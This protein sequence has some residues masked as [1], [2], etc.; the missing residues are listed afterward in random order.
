MGKWRGGGLWRGAA[1]RPA[2]RALL[3]RAARG[4]SPR[5]LARANAASGHGCAVRT[6]RGRGAGGGRRRP[7]EAWRAGR[8]GAEKERGREKEERRRRRG[9]EEEEK[10]A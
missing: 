3:G 6:G 5:E 4:P 10:G 8:L 9:K 7:G 1:R 2:C